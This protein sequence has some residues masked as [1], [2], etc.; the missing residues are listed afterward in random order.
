MLFSFEETPESRAQEYGGSPSHELIYKAVGETDDFLVGQY[1][2]GATPLTVFR[3]AGVLYRRGIRVDPDGHAQYRVVVSYGKPD[4]TTTPVGS[5]TFSFDTTGG[6][7]HVTQAKQHV[8]TYPSGGDLH[9]GAINVKQTDKG[10]DV[11]GVDIIIPALKFTAS[12]RHPQGIVTPAYVKALASITGTTNSE[13]FLGFE[14]GE[15]LFL[16]ATGSDGTEAEA[17]VSYQFLASANGTGLSFGDIT[18]V[19][20]GG[21]EYLWLSYSDEVESGEA[22]KQPERAFVERLY[23]SANWSAVFGWS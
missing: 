3:P 20:K 18:G 8:A 10:A 6:T 21:H 14:P 1:A 16:G 12:F 19:N 23:D 22:V 5:V 13:S 4:R 2:L 15:L 9:K 17:E 7:L 11:E